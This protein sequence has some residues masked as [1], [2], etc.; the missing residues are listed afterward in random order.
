MNVKIRELMKMKKSLFIAALLCCAMGA[1]A[2]DYTHLTFQKNDSSTLSISVASLTMTFDGEQLV[3]TNGTATYQLNVSDLARMYFSD[4][5]PTG[6]TQLN[7]NT[8]HN[9]EIYTPAGIRLG[10]YASLEAFAQQAD[11]GLYVVKSNG[12]T[13][14]TI[15]K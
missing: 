8:N 5:T 3:A 2:D 9:V 6:I 14:K 13:Y 15:V 4:G 1:K 12:R 7:N 11:K 10:S